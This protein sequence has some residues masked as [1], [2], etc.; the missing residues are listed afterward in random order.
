MRNLKITIEYD[1]IGY[2]GWQVQSRSKSKPSIQ[3]TIEKAL[4][5]IL[6]ERIKLIGAG[7]TDAGVHAEAQAA[8]FKTQSRIP[9]HKLQYAL[10]SALPD[11]IVITAVKKVKPDFHS[12]FDAKS[13]SYR[14]VILNS[15][16]RSPI[17]R[18]YVYFYPH[19]L[20]VKL[21]RR[22]VRCLLGKHDFKA[23]CASGSSAKSTVRNIKNLYIKK[24][25][26]PLSAKR[27]PLITIEIEA[28]GFLYN[29]ARNI[30]GTLIEI[31]RGKFT[32]GSMK[33]ILAA[34]DR[35]LA[36]PTAPAMGLCLLEV[37][38]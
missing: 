26:Y 37:K 30:A 27:Y 34:R 17:L 10:N 21:M 31:G 29:M 2:C 22:E 7:R 1:G 14:Y 9:L 36:G 18:N 11:D 25:N 12:R 15:K 16:C 24:L 5:K 19:Y 32:P 33:R 20:D 6:R 8:N 35:K 23:F 38:Y 3:A 13:K 4:R 28:G